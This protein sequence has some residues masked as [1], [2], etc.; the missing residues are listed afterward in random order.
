MNLWQVR[1]NL[2][3]GLAKTMFIKE[4]EI[5]KKNK[6]K[7]LMGKAGRHRLAGFLIKKSAKFFAKYVVKN[8]WVVA[9]ILFIVL[10]RLILGISDLW[11]KYFKIIS[12][13]RNLASVIKNIDLKKLDIGQKDEE[14]V[15]AVNDE[16]IDCT[17]VAEYWRPDGNIYF[18][19]NKIKLKNKGEAGSIFFKD[20][21]SN[22]LNFEIVFRSFLKSGVNANISFVN[23]YGGELRYSV[24]DGDFKTIRSFYLKDFIV[25][26]NKELIL[27]DEINGAEDIGFKVDIVERKNASQALGSLTYYGKEKE[28]HSLDFGDMVIPRGTYLSVGFGLDAKKEPMVEGAGESYVEIKTCALKENT[29]SKILN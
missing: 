5:K 1:S 26:D 7:K 6:S 4:I 10:P 24:G 23:K 14:I 12:E 16:A 8:I 19:E 18:E 21:V 29:P 28:F 13:P 11:P 3:G 27:L 25:E 2:F 17:N 20:Q 15:S 22:F 9:V